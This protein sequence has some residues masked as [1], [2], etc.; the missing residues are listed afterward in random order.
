V[1]ARTDRVAPPDDKGQSD[2][3]FV[4]HGNTKHSIHP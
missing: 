3:R 2:A 1:V 4:M